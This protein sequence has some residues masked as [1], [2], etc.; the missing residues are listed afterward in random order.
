MNQPRKIALGIVVLAAAAVLFLVFL[1]DEEGV[2]TPDSP[3]VI[4]ITLD[5]T[6][7]DRLGCYGYPNPL[8]PEIDK[9]AEEGIRFDLAIAQAAVT[10]VS[11]AS[12]LTG[13][14]PFQH[15][16]RVLHGSSCYRLE[17]GIPTL[18]T[19]L[20][21][22]V[23]NTSAF[24]SSFP[25]SENFW[26][27]HGFDIF[28]TGLEGSVEEKM[29]ISPDGKANWAVDRNQRRADLTTDQA[30]GWIKE[31]RDP[32]FMWLHFFDPHDGT[33]TPP[34]KE[35]MPYMTGADTS[36]QKDLQR[37]MYDAEVAYMDRQLG[38]LFKCLRETGLYDR[39]MIIITNDH[40]EGLG[41]HD[42]WFHRILYQEQ[43]RMPLIF[44]L[45]GDQGGRVIPDM[46]RS[47]DIMPT[48]LEQ[49]GVKPPPMTGKSL[50]GLIRGEQE[51]PRTAYADALIRLDDNRPSHA[52]DIYN[53]LMYCVIKGPWKLIHRRF[54][55][56]HSE[57][58]RLDQDPLEK[59]NVIDQF[60][61]K[62]KELFEFLDQPG[63]M[64]E[65]LIPSKYDSEQSQRLKELG[66]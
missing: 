16:L 57:L 27:Q 34:K 66:Y 11:H 25:E 44:R 52:K 40:G 18:A 2:C 1:P 39:T 43:I 10:P 36:N 50:M 8:T 63:I 51:Q 58:Y 32:F 47:I 30:I 23:W 21:K 61:D 54:N 9:V 19:T 41:D 59:N 4:L 62:R 42:W 14:Y 45:P 60:P 49:L 6:R 17:E 22:E 28:D 65:K 24:V 33:I 3:S 53:D 56:E 5:T 38:R 48:V 37:R 15:G 29:R 55:P 7:A 35:W 31:N 12:I 26:L 20:L 13:L 64:I 46:V